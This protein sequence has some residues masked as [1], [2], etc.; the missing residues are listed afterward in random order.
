MKNHDTHLWKKVQNKINDNG[1]R[2]VADGIPGPKTANGILKAFQRIEDSLKTV[3]EDLAEEE[4]AKEPAAPTDRNIRNA[5]DSLDERSRKNILTLHPKVQ[6][7]FAH[8]CLKGKE[9]AKELK[10]GDYVAISGHRT[11]AEQNALYAKGRTAPG[12]KVTNARGGYSRHNF[13]VAVDYAVFGTS[14]SY[15]DGASPRF[16]YKVHKAVA[17]WAKENYPIEWGGDWTSFVDA[18]HFQWDN[19]L[20]TSQMR[21]RVRN[22]QSVV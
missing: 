18:P 3:P 15:L 19:G 5:V 4:K 13:G 9:I 10:A 20:S 17:E 16:A 11:Y 6:L 8:I 12:P 7:A 14:G 2:L 1:G 22:N 21:E